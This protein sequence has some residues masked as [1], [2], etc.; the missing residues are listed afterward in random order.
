MAGTPT[1]PELATM[2][3]EILCM[4]GDNLS[5]HEIK[6]LTLT[7]KQ[8]R[9]IFLPKLCK[10]L[11]FSGNMK[12]L[13][14]SLHAYYTRKTA[15]FRHLVHHH[16]SFVTFEVTNFDDIFKMNAW[17][18]G[19]GVKTIPIGRFLADTPSLHGVV[20]D[21]WLQNRKEAHKFL[22]LIRKGPDWA[23]PKHLYFTKYVEKSTM[24]KIVGKFKAGALKG[25]A[26]P[27][28]SLTGCHYDELARSGAHLTSLRLNKYS[29]LRQDSSALTSLSDVLINR[30]SK[31][32]PQLES[33]NIY[34][35]T[36]SGRYM[37]HMNDR[38]RYRWCRKIDKVASS[39]RKMRRL[40]RFA[41]TLSEAQFS[42]SFIDALRTKLL[43]IVM[44]KGLP[45]VE[46]RG[47]EGVYIL[48]ITYFA[49][50]AKSPEEVCITTGCPMFY[51]ATLTN[52]V[53]NMSEESSEDP[54][55][56]DVKAELTRGTSAP[57]DQSF[58]LLLHSLT[59]PTSLSALEKMPTEVLLMIGSH[60]GSIAFRV[61]TLVS[62]RLRSVLLLRLFKRITF[63]GT[64]R[65][66]AH[67]MRSFLSGEYKHLMMTI[68]P[69]LKSVTIRFEPH[70]LAEESTD[71]HLSTNRIAV[72][73]EFISKL[74]SIDLISFDNQVRS[75]H[76]REIAFTEAL[77]NAPQWNGPKAVI[78]CGHRNLRLFTQFPQYT[79]KRHPL[80]LKSAC[81]LLKGLRADVSAI[82]SRSRTL[83]CMSSN[84]LRAMNRDFPHLEALVLD[85]VD[86]HTIV[87]G[88]GRIY[89]KPYRPNLN[90]CVEK[91]IA[92]LKAMP[93]LRR[94]AF[95]LQK[96]WLCNEYDCELF[97]KRVRSLSGDESDDPLQATSEPNEWPYWL[98][99]A[100]QQ[101]E[102]HSELITRIL[103][104]V[105]Q[106]KEL[107]IVLDPLEYHR[108]TKTENI[109]TVRRVQFG[110]L[111][112]P[113][114][115]PYVL[116]DID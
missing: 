79:A 95:T 32:F 15:S 35:K 46:A 80:A 87:S 66:L 97:N 86:A 100:A 107:C 99:T 54:S 88:G 37:H 48:L 108:G 85:Q 51:R 83:A 33:L 23:G 19:Y 27:H 12:E 109:V 59:T 90:E 61:A 10:H 92:Q 41:F 81:P 111:E 105:P 36:R 31:D 40:R 94:F 68:L 3:T 6:E 77:G 72:I 39:L 4:I 104:A 96:Y 64:L 91:L 110:Y 42:E 29:F 115:F 52:G 13:T 93:R 82:K 70:S 84:T 60:V 25:I 106:L 75:N 63:S 53:W 43:A 74:S 26:A 44:K 47:L 57:S 1:T 58:T 113:S 103:E 56:K 8:F 114:Q 38:D 7:S 16:T 34:D 20:F 5:V 50:H 116:A 49:A 101:E 112:K 22:S 67:D 14:D 65:K 9:E 89:K 71:S 30:I 73:S 45:P 69:A 18:L 62:K 98:P 17:L 11:K 28:A 76:S 55:Q 2:P 24:G 21:I 78:F 102:W